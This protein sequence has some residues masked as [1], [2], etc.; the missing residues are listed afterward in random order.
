MQSRLCMIC[1]IYHL[2]RRLE[3]VCFLRGGGVPAPTSSS[4]ISSCYPE[5]TTLHWSVLPRQS[6]LLSLCKII[7]LKNVIS[8]FTT[9]G[10]TFHFADCTYRC[11]EN[12][13]KFA[14]LTL[15]LTLWV[16]AQQC[17]FAMWKPAINNSYQRLS[18][19]VDW[20]VL[21]SQPASA[22]LAEQA[23]PVHHVRPVHHQAATDIQ[24]H[25]VEQAQTQASIFS[26]IV[27]AFLVESSPSLFWSFSLWKAPHLC[28]DHLACGKFPIFVFDNL[29]C[30]K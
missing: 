22:D 17:P 3:Q 10:K 30:G 13:F 15:K 26:C 21:P 20:F 14:H 4:T 11:S 16:S 28:F 18:Y 7:Q 2:H 29:A 23:V 12:T 1:Y 6:I 24:V 5:K 8:I 9:K 25:R 27:P 19:L